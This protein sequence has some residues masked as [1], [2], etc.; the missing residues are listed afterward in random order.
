[1]FK[2]RVKFGIAMDKIFSVFL[3]DLKKE[4]PQIT[5]VISSVNKRNEPSNNFMIKHGFI[6]VKPSKFKE[7]SKTELPEIYNYYVL[8]V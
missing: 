1:M 3:R 4:K 2:R 7:I 6:K 5:K 8:G